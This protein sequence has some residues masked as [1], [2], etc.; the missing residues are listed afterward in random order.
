MNYDIYI[1][2]LGAI[3]EADMRIA[4]LTIVAGENGTGKSFVTKMFY[5]VLNIIILDIFSNEVVNLCADLNTAIDNAND[6]FKN[7]SLISNQT[8]NLNELEKDLD[9]FLK[10][11]MT[12]ILIR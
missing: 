2:N 7:L 6:L 4:P 5:S 12:S 9:I 10:H 1:E 3:K 11:S 8:D